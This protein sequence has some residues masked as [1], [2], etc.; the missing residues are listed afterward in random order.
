MLRAICKRSFAT[1]KTSTGLVGL[2]V[3]PNGRENLLSLSGKILSSVQK[4]PAEA[5]YRIDVEKWFNYIQKVATD[6]T[7]VRAIENEIDLGQVEE[8][9]EMG[10]TE[11][12]LIDYYYGK[13]AL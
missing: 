1:Y 6:N 7:D 9:L 4:I 11:L 5:Q 8:L 2:A 13:M 10:N 3:D 12:E